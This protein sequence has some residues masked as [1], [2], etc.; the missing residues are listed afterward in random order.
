VKRAMLATLF[1]SAGTPMLLAG[2]EMDRTQGGNNNAYCQDNETS[3]VDWR[4]AATPQ[5]RAL[6]RF[7]A[8]LIAL[9]G[10]L[11]TLR[12]PVFLHGGARLGQG[13][14]DIAWFDQHGQPMAPEAWNE[15]EARTLALR[16]AAPAEAGPAGAVEVTMLLMNADGAGH[17]FALPGPRLDWTLVMDSAHPDLP[18]RPVH[19]EAVPVAP[20]AVVLL[21]ATLP[22]P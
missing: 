14:N 10:R 17:A 1:A 22:A 6:D 11:S 5:A 15:P 18:E 13:L 21:A 2:D 9:R 3:W 4:R 19:D 8:R 16:R 12:P 20:R 7:V